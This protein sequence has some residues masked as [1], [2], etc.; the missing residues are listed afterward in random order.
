V[1]QSLSA[2]KERFIT[3]LHSDRTALNAIAKNQLVTSDTQRRELARL[4]HGIAGA[5][6]S[7]GFDHLS[8][9]ASQMEAT[10]EADSSPVEKREALTSLIRELD[11]VIADMKTGH[12]L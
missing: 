11:A 3:R 10:L 12:P 6:G 9:R 2:L 1:V 7:F 5:G 8:I 4:A